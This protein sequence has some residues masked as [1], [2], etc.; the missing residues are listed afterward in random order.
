MRCKEPRRLLW[1]DVESD[2]QAKHLDSLMAPQ[3]AEGWGKT[4]HFCGW[5]EVLSSYMIC[6]VSRQQRHF[7]RAVMMTCT[8][9]D[10]VVPAEL[11]EHF[12]HLSQ[13]SFIEKHPVGHMAPMTAPGVVASFILKAITNS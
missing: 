12:A 4:T 8:Q 13:A 9:R 2:A 1:N 3:P 10:L 5:R 6:E 11:Q 7:W